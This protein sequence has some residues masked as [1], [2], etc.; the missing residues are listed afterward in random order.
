[1]EFDPAPVIQPSAVNVDKFLWPIG[2]LIIG[3]V[4]LYM[5][6]PIQSNLCILVTL[7]KWQRDHYIQAGF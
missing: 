3:G 1:M 5:W 7:R 2:D 6:L 4:P